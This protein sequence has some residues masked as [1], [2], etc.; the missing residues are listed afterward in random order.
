MVLSAEIIDVFLRVLQQLRSE[1]NQ[2][3]EGLEEHAVDTISNYLAGLS[4]VRI[5]ETFW[6]QGKLDHYLTC[7]SMQS[8]K[9]EGGL[10][11]AADEFGAEWKHAAGAPR[12]KEAK[13]RHLAGSAIPSVRLRLD[14]GTSI[15]ASWAES[16][17]E[18]GLDR[19][20]RSRF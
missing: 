13:G 11:R 20:V 4:S 8:V 16:S 9:N 15:L 19:M 17:A 7:F 10:L 5:N 12:K 18:P 2:R 3:L 14:G 6:F 1:S